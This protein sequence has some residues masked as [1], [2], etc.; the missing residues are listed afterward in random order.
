V[1]YFSI[2][3][4]K[5]EQPIG[6]TSS[7]HALHESFPGTRD[8]LESCADACITH[9][10]SLSTI[11][12]EKS[13]E[14]HT[15]LY[16]AIVK[17]LPDEHHQVKD[18]SGPDLLSSLLSYST[19]LSSETIADVKQA[20]L[21]TCDQRLFQRLRLSP[22]FSPVSIA[23]QMLLGGTISSDKIEVEDIEGDAFIMTFEVPLFHKRMVV[24]K[25]ICLEFIARNR[26]W[27]LEFFIAPEN[28]VH[29]GSWGVALS[30]LETSP[31]AWLNSRLV[32]PEAIPPSTKPKPIEV[33]LRSNSHQGQLQAPRRNNIQVMLQD[34]LMGSNL[35]YGKNPYV[36]LD[37]TLRG[38]LESRLG[39]QPNFEC[40]IC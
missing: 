20:C 29:P 39:T 19:P 1:V 33:K 28:G 37:E 6:S 30:L 4:G 34:S 23:E 16:W 40:I 11:L 8:I 7:P 35:Q 2:T 22:E 25:V 24:S 32:I 10:L 36:G 26:M 27:R 3:K 15:P 31:P 14:N 21:V 17:R 38:R 12:Q 13:I 5:D 9:S 18:A